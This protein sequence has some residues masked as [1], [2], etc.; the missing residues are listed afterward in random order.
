MSHASVN[1]HQTLSLLIFSEFY[2][3]YSCYIFVANPTVKCQ[4]FCWNYLSRNFR[5]MST[6]ACRLF[7]KLSSFN[8]QS[9]VHRRHKEAQ[10]QPRAV[11]IVRVTTGSA[12][13]PMII[14]RAS[15]RLTQYNRYH[16]HHFK[17]SWMLCRNIFFVCVCVRVFLHPPSTTVRHCLFLHESKAISVDHL[18]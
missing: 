17:T 13:N 12:S 5:F 9:N 15:N 4:H 16:H 18:I 10:C 11:C 6:A 2:W 3:F 1:S 14:V 7:M 8:L